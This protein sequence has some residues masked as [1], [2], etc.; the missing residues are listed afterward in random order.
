MNLFLEQ[1]AK[2]KML[3]TDLMCV[4]LSLCVMLCQQAEVQLKSSLY[5]IICQWHATQHSAASEDIA[6][7]I[8]RLPQAST[9]L[10]WVKQNSKTMS[11][12][13]QQCIKHCEKAVNGRLTTA[14]KVLEHPC[15]FKAG[16]NVVAI[17]L[18]VH[19][20]CTN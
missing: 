1:A 3:G 14:E 19:L 15:A 4:Y 8:C 2:D 18:L 7:E 10:Q 5:D 17:V 16:L 6:T 11:P 12:D 9:L 20:Q 13:I